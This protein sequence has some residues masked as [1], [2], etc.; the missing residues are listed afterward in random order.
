HRTEEFRA[1]VKDCRTNLKSYFRTA[2]DVIILT[3]SGT[4]GMEAAFVNQ[5]S[6]GEKVLVASCGKFGD[7]WSDIARAYGI[8]HETLRTQVGESLDPAEVG[9]RARAMRPKALL[10]T[11]SETSVGVKN[12]L[13][14]LSA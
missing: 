14:V 1:I 4:G 13:R 9:R 8:E 3:A 10:L 11:A 12:D 7:R 5:V 2:E 6:P